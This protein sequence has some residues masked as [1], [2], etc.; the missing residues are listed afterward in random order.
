MSSADDIE[1]K[2]SLS[3]A[4]HTTVDGAPSGVTLFIR[5]ASGMTRKLAANDSLLI[6]LYGPYPNNPTASIMRT[7]RL[8]IITGGIGVSGVLPW[9]FAHPNVKFTWSVK[10][11]AEC[12]VDS[13]NTV[14]TG[15][16]DK[17]IRVGS[18]LDIQA[19]LNQEVEAGWK[20]VGV[21]ACG[22]GGLCDDVRAAVCVAAKGSTRFELE[23]DAYSW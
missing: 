15:V 2:I 6:L 22:P 19:L 11:S 13:L 7:D 12:L 20:K 9:V 8:L 4:Y 17:D 10:K 3:T 16:D 1:N 23:V 14:L 18:R 5:K 21:V